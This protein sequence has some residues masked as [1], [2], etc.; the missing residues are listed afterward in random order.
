MENLMDVPIVMFTTS[1]RREEIEKAYELGACGYVVKPDDFDEFVE[2]LRQ[3]KTYWLKT[4]E[5][6][7]AVSAEGAKGK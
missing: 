4:V 7:S 1:A 5:K 3:V 2:K 6:P